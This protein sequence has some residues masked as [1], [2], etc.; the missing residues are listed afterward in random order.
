VTFGTW[1]EVDADV[2]ERVARLW[3][4]PE[5][6]DLVVAGRLANAVPPWGDRLL[7]TPA[8][9]TVLNEDHSPY[10]T[11][12]DDPLLSGVLSEEWPSATILSALPH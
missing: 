8:T 6:A 12:S 11:G 3:S 1:L 2:L 4:T 5:Y 9:A 7:G 10:I